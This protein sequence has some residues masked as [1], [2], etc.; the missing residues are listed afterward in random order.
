MMRFYDDLEI[1]KIVED[2]IY[3]V[4]GRL[5]L[6]I[7]SNRNQQNSGLEELLPVRNDAF[8]CLIGIIL[9]NKI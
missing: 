2:K 9:S 5:W 3:E 8:Q 7:L 6:G 4:D 1:P